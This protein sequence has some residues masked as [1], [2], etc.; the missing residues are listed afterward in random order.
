[1][2]YDVMVCNLSPCVPVLHS[3]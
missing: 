2:Y 3:I 1:M